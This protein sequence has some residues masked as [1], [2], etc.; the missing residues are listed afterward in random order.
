VEHELL[1]SAPPLRHDEQPARLATR[2]KR[3]LDR[4]PAGDDLVARLDQACFGRLQPGTI[5]GWPPSEVRSGAISERTVGPV[6]ECTRTRR[7]I[8]IRTGRPATGRAE[9][10]IECGASWSGSLEWFIGGARTGPVAEPTGTFEPAAR[11][12]ESWARSLIPVGRSIRPWT[13][14]STRTLVTW[15]AIGRARRPRLPSGGSIRTTAEAEPG[16]FRP[17]TVETWAVALGTAGPR[18]VTARA[19]VAG[20]A[21]GPIEGGTID[22]RP[23]P[24]R[25]IVGATRNSRVRPEAAT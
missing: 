17:G 8:A 7:P 20:T 19:L 11:P 5:E 13:C 3:L 23:L 24:C 6:A 9:R 2:N 22:L 16:A 25:P 15:R 4:P 12:I 18:S 1:E 10:P 14:V 21:T